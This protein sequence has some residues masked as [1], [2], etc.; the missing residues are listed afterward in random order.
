MELCSSSQAKEQKELRD[1]CFI[2]FI[3]EAKLKV[4]IDNIVIL[5]LQICVSNLQLPIKHKDFKK[6]VGGAPN[7]LIGCKQ[8]VDYCRDLGSLITCSPLR[9]AVLQHEAALWL[10]GP[11][12]PEHP[13][14]HQHQ[15]QRCSGQA[16]RPGTELGAAAQAAGKDPR[17]PERPVWARLVVPAF[18]L[19]CRLCVGWAPDVC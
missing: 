7:R 4:D 8:T 16:L 17:F 12:P 2:P 11:H 1:E 15:Y 19:W 10:P 14:H 3:S 6:K 9:R 5:K 18:Y 13:H